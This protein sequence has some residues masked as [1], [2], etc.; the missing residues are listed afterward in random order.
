MDGRNPVHAGIRAGPLC[1]G[2]PYA[3]YAEVG[4]WIF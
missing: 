1:N 4:R 2:C 3:I